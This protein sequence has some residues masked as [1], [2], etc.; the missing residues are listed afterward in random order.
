MR[1][2]PSRAMRRLRRMNQ[3]PKNLNLHPEDPPVLTGQEARGGKLY[4]RSSGRR[5]MALFFL[6]ALVTALA[7]IIYFV[8]GDAAP[9]VRG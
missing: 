1:Q 4:E 8:G 7:L 6:F 2:E 3:D 5:W 9:A